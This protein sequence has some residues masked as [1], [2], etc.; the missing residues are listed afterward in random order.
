[1]EASFIRMWWYIL[2]CGYNAK[3][4]EVIVF[5]GIIV[6]AS[7]L[8]CMT[9]LAIHSCPDNGARCNPVTF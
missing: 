4:L 1:M 7:L 8:G 6:V 5:K 3:S 9:C 2:I